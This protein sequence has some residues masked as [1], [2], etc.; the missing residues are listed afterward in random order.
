VLPAERELALQRSSGNFARQLDNG[1][2]NNRVL[3]KHQHPSNSFADAAVLPS[4][5]AQN[6]PEYCGGQIDH[7]RRKLMLAGPSARG[8]GRYVLPHGLRW[9]T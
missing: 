2:P 3:I 9:R 5:P 8:A 1:C 4:T 6:W 7:D